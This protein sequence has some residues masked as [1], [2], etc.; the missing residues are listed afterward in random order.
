MLVYGRISM[1]TELVEGLVCGV[2]LMNCFSG[3][4]YHLICITQ[5]F[6]Y[7]KTG[8]PI[9]QYYK[10]RKPK[11]SCNCSSLFVMF[12]YKCI[13]NACPFSVMSTWQL[14][15]PTTQLQEIE[16]TQ[17]SYSVS[18]HTST[19]PLQLSFDRHQWTGRI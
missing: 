16:D 6:R 11:N 12:N 18:T 7:H 17:H 2:L 15:K 13:F 5:E 10:V 9:N 3:D 19:V 4:R 8:R 14:E 1:K